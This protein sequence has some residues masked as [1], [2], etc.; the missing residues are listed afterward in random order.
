M[1]GG[2]E[3]GT[4]ALLDWIF[5]VFGVAVAITG[6]WIQLHPERILPAQSLDA[7]WAESQQDARAMS[8]IR[9]LGSCFL[10]MGS[11]FAIQMT[12]DGNHRR[13]GGSNFR[14]DASQG[15]S[16]PQTRAAST[17]LCAAVAA[18]ESSRTAVVARAILF[19]S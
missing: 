19:K 12:V 6:S 16:E 14:R 10:F 15:P 13:R 2:T 7:A 1:R 3:S 18:E 11:F 5:V 9:V 8:Q 4:M 17:P